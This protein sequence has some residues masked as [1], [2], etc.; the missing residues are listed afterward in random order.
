MYCLFPNGNV[1]Q[2]LDISGSLFLSICTT[3]KMSLAE[4]TKKSSKSNEWLSSIYFNVYN[5]FII[6]TRE[7]RYFHGYELADL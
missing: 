1:T 4:N 5:G 7:P 6:F 3:L 2:K